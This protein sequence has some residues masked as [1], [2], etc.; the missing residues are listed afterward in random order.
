MTAA[1][2][3]AHQ[4]HE[5][6]LHAGITSAT[7]TQLTSRTIVTID[8][9]GRP[10]DSPYLVGPA[11]SWAWKGGRLAGTDPHHSVTLAEAHQRLADR[12][13]E[14]DGWWRVVHHFP[15]DSAMGTAVKYGP[16]RG[17]ATTRPPSWPEDEVR[18]VDVRRYDPTRPDAWWETT[19]VN[20]FGFARRV[21]ARDR[22]DAQW[23]VDIAW[24]GHTL[25]ATQDHAA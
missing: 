12:A 21:R 3:S 16:T 5:A 22:A 24:P 10:S 6:A 7:L 25:T 18:L 14:R 1:P 20:A 8:G 11:L 4:L 13:W 23:M 17:Q 2:R 9:I 19:A 15:K